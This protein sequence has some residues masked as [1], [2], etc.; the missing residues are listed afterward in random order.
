M[1]QTNQTNG[2]ANQTNKNSITSVFDHLF[3]VKE[4]DKLTLSETYKAL[5]NNIA[6]YVSSLKSNL[7]GDVMKFRDDVLGAVVL[8]K[9]NTESSVT[10]TPTTTVMDIKDITEEINTQSITL[11]IPYD[12]YGVEKEK[13]E[14]LSSKVKM[15]LMTNLNVTQLDESVSFKVAVT[16]ATQSFKTVMS[17]KGQEIATISGTLKYGIKEGNTVS[18]GAMMKTIYPTVRLT[19]NEFIGPRNISMLNYMAAY[20]DSAIETNKAFDLVSSSAKENKEL[21]TILNKL[22]ATIDLKD[23]AQLKKMFNP[24]QGKTVEYRLPFRVSPQD[25]VNVNGHVNGVSTIITPYEATIDGSLTPILSTNNE[26]NALTQLISLNV[27]GAI[28]TAVGFAY[29]NEINPATLKQAITNIQTQ[30]GQI[31]GN[32]GT[33][34]FGFSSNNVVLGATVQQ[35]NNNNEALLQM[36][37]QMMGK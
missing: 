4:I 17:V 23:I 13:V 24:N 15:G 34:L 29:V 32:T 10:I 16:K 25:K 31:S 12:E 8:V 14:S 22:G 28:K 36:M 3:S 21:I 18:N 5:N 19:I 26:E 1:T 27:N 20:T 6:K 9:P 7:D 2:Q 30:T 35:G 11:K 33:N 37:Q